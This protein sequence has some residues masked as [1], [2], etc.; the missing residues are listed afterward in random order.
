MYFYRARYYDQK[1]GRFVTKDPISFAGGD[2][3]LYAYV[4]N[5]PVNLIDPDGLS[6]LFDPGNGGF[7]LPRFGGGG[8]TYSSSVGGKTTRFISG[9]KIINKKTGKPCEGTVDLKPTLDRINSGERFPHRN[10]GSV[11]KNNEKLLPQKAE[12]YYKEFVQPTPGIK[13][14]GP[15]LIITGTGGEMYY[16]PDHYRTFIPLK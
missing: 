9:V 15:Q 10:D 3:N 4:L 14:P 16:T 12:G 5:N 6:P 11:F 13:D 7:G 1:V 2:V 8:G